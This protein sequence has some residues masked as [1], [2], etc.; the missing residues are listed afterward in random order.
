MSNTPEPGAAAAETPPNNPNSPAPG[1]APAAA[2]GAAPAVPAAVAA[3]PGAGEPGAAP[4]AVTPP[5]GGEPHV[6][7]PWGDNWRETA[8]GDDA[9]ILK[10]LQR[11]TSPKEVAKA[12]VEAKARIRSGELQAPLPDNATAE[13][14]TEFRQRNG[15]PEKADGY[16]EKLPDGLV[17]GEDDKPLFASF[18]EQLHKHNVKPAV[19]HDVVKWY[20]DMLATEDKARV[21]ADATLKTETED[22]LRGEWGG[23]YRVNVNIVNAMLSQAPKTVQDMIA[24]ARTPDGTPI[25]GT[26]DFARWMATLAREVN[27]IVTIPGGSSGDPMKTVHEEIAAIETLMQ[28]DRKAYNAD[29]SKAARLMQ[30]YDIKAQMTRKAG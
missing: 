25:K 3:V 30:L 8:A 1:A 16:L 29:P 13:Q 28:K 22:A 14:V 15:I 4:A 10:D 6:P 26:A 9:A 12:L 18:A 27:P 2:N 11:Y 24:E 7:G 17:I 23:D 5:A 19:V 20:S 21:D